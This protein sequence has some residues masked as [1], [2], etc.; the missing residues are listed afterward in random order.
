MR[1]QGGGSGGVYFNTLRKPTTQPTKLAEECDSVWSIRRTNLYVNEFLIA[2]YVVWRR[3]RRKVL[4]LP[5]L[6]FL[7]SVLRRNDKMVVIT[8]LAC[9]LFT[10][11]DSLLYRLLVVSFEFK[12]FF[13]LCGNDV[14]KTI[15]RNVDVGNIIFPPVQEVRQD[16]PV[17]GLMADD[18]N[19]IRAPI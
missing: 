7:D 17:D 12:K 2:K 19:I 9:L 1:R 6:Y 15:L 5:S 14:I 10:I 16:H 13:V 11:H 4:H 18:H 3:R 8:R